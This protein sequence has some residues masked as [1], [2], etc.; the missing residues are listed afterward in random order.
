MSTT[1]RSHLTIISRS[2]NIS[3]T[4]HSLQGVTSQNI[5]RTKSL[6]LLRIRNRRSATILNSHQNSLRFRRNFLRLRIQ[7][8]RLITTL[9]QHSNRMT[10]LLTLP[11]SNL[12][13]INNSRTQTQSSIA[14]PLK[15]RNKRFRIRRMVLTRSH[16]HRNPNQTNSKRISIRPLIRQKRSSTNTKKPKRHSQHVQQITHRT[17]HR[18]LIR[19]TIHHTRITSNQR[20][21]PIQILTNHTSTRTH[22][23][24]TPRTFINSSSPQFSRS[25]I[26]QTIRRNR[27]ITSLISLNQSIT[28]R[29]N[30]NASIRASTTP[31]QRRTALLLLNHTRTSTSTRYHHHR[32]NNGLL[33]ITMISQ[34]R[35]QSRQDTI[36][37]HSPNILSNLLTNNS[38]NNQYSP[39]RITPFT[40]IRTANLRSSIRN[41]VPQSIIRTRNRITLSTINSSSIR[42]KGINSRLR[43]QTSK[44]I[45]RIRHSTLTL[46]LKLLR[47][48]RQQKF[49][50]LQNSLSRMLNTY[51]MNRQ[52][53]KAN[54][55][56]LRTTTNQHTR[57]I[58]QISTNNRIN[59][60]RLSHTLIKGQRTH[61]FSSSPTALTA[62]HQHHIQHKRNHSR[63][64]LTNQ[65]TTRVSTLRQNPNPYSRLTQVNQ[66]HLRHTNTQHT[67]HRRRTITI[68]PHH[69]TTTP[70]RF[71]S[72][73]NTT[74]NLSNT[75]NGN[76][77]RIGISTSLNRHIPNIKRIRNGPQKHLNHRRLNISQ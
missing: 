65:A 54:S 61:R 43:R 32:R 52:L 48:H 11:S 75:N 68:S 67:S 16:R 77:P 45:L 22:T 51:L 13:L 20:S 38:L 26:S 25:L 21:I 36:L 37:S 66:G 3:F 39:S 19:R 33:Y 27:R 31:Q 55:H 62:R 5:S 44:G 8:Q 12:T 69:V 70:R 10:S 58:S 24:L 15:V 30:I 2:H 59:S 47:T 34:G 74:A 53:R 6:I 42:P 28:S 41:L 63:T 64:P 40:L 7:S 14:T 4:L 18:H 29:R 17:I 1:R 73:P 49:L 76:K 23:R 46:M 72:S 50:T 57:R 9:L 56:S 71:S 60:I 35:L